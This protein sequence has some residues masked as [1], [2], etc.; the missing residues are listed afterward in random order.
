VPQHLDVLGHP[1]GQPVPEH[2]VGVEPLQLVVGARGRERLP[3]DLGDPGQ[4]GDRARGRAAPDAL[5][6]GSASLGL[7]VITGGSRNPGIACGARATVGYRKRGAR[8]R[9]GPLEGLSLT[10]KAGPT[11]TRVAAQARAHTGVRSLRFSG[12]PAA[13]LTCL[14]PRPVRP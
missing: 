1:G 2:R 5:G 14:A 4:R 6:A 9:H 11:G 3:G 7:G 10:R 12:G 8:H 13:Q